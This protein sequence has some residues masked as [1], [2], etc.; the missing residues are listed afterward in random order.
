MKKHHPCANNQELSEMQEYLKTEA[1]TLSSYNIAL[2]YAQFSI[3]T[4]NEVDPSLQ[5]KEEAGR[6]NRRERESTHNS[7]HGYREDS[8]STLRNRSQRSLDGGLLGAANAE[9][10]VG[11]GCGLGGWGVKEVVV[12]SPS[13]SDLMYVSSPGTEERHGGNVKKIPLDFR[14][15]WGSASKLR[16]LAAVED[17]VEEDDED[18]TRLDLDSPFVR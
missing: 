13:C 10:K 9:T 7:V 15:R 14:A 2:A 8:A 6:Q 12:K 11:E 5:E 1:Q 18:Q 4:A 16:G 3:I 17:L